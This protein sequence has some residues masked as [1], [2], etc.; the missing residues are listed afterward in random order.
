MYKRRLLSLHVYSSRLT[1][2]QEIYSN[3]RLVPASM[4]N[5]KHCSNLC[6]HV[7]KGLR[8]KYLES[9]YKSDYHTIP[10][11]YWPGNEA[12][13]PVTKAAIT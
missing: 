2:E 3:S 8:N 1:T 13:Y 10:P 6:A 12:N 7:Y 9:V 11:V 4:N 5:N